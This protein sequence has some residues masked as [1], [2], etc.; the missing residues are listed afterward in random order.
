[1]DRRTFVQSAAIS[2][3]GLAANRSDLFKGMGLLLSNR[4]PVS[5]NGNRFV[6]FCI[7]IRTTPWEV[8]RD[9]KLH[10]RDEAAWHTL[11]GV[12]WMR[13]A[14]AKNN[15][16]GRL[17]WGFTLNALED[18]RKNYVEI[19]NYAAEC[20]EKYGD[21]VSYFPG[22]FP[23]M[24][25]PRERINREMTEAIETITGFVGKGYRPQAIMGGFL[26]ANNLQY[27]AEKEKIHA[28][29]A[30]IWSQSNIDGGGADGSPSYPF[31]PSKEHFCKPAQNSS[32]FIDC[33]N[34]DGWTMDFICAR[35]SG[36]SDQKITGFNS[37]RGVGPL[38]T[39]VGW[40]LDLGHREVM[41]TQSIHFDKGFEL[42]GFGWVTNIWE[43][44]LVYEFGKDLI[45][46]ALEMWVTDTKKR[47]PDT[48]FVTFGEYG[49]IWRNQYKN[50]DKWNYRFEER[51]SGLGDSYNN[52]EIKWFMNKEFRLAILHDWHQNTPEMVI[53][54]TR[55]D[56]HAKEPAD[57]SPAHP[58]KNWSLINEINQK[59]LRPQ[60]KP[61]LIKEL[62]KKDQDLITGYYPGLM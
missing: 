53:D 13:E 48:Q 35:R 45:C 58:D 39:Y 2:G 59:G 27:L 11:E 19:R 61:Q 9:V 17:T 46:G 60:D 32:D 10:P 12:K 21:E 7:M 4:P 41:H 5:L 29:H 23:A 30:V 54:F 62:S 57:P 47:W 16:D 34:L 28:V 51:G 3:A 1:M 52:L 56:L 31:Y 44:Q 15:P 14:F 24:Y 26:S 40:G 8:S 25:L 36:A 6:T 33:V 49:N 42:N 22:Y 38:E 37:R 55:Y 18:K 43:A 50:N 20:Q